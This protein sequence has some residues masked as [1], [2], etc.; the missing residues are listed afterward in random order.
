MVSEINALDEILKGEWHV[1][2]PQYLKHSFQIRSLY[3][4]LLA[5]AHLR[6]S[7]LLGAHVRICRGK[8]LFET[9]LELMGNKSVL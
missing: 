6:R 9:G 2:L 5:E 7:F 4:L 8:F 1:P 3:S